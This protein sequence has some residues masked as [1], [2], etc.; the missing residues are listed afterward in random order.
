[1]NK[2]KE[3]QEDLLQ[4]KDNNVHRDGEYRTLMHKGRKTKGRS[5]MGGGGFGGGKGGREEG[6]WKRR[7]GERQRERDT[8]HNDCYY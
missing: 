3:E 1:M 8:E 2:K 6:E 7:D 5:G 4:V